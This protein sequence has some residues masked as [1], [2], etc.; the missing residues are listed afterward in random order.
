[1]AESPIDSR[2]L[3]YAVLLCVW[4]GF[5]GLLWVVLGMVPESGAA[6]SVGRF[7]AIVVTL[8]VWTEVHARIA[9]GTSRWDPRAWGE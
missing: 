6:N 5:M 8:A 3:R 9:H 4:V 1:M 2:P 7:A